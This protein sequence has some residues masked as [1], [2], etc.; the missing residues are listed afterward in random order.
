MLHYAVAVHVARHGPSLCCRSIYDPIYV[1]LLKDHSLRELPSY[2]NPITVRV[3]V[4]I[5]VSVSVRVR[6]KVKVRITVRLQSY[7]RP[8]PKLNPPEPSSHGTAELPT[9]HPL[10]AVRG[11]AI[12]PLPRPID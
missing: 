3:M 4:R 8:H 11:L 10:P 1:L 2:P 12:R 5:S 9:K 6:V 7:S